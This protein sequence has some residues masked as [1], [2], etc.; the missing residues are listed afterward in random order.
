MV[1]YLM[2]EFLLSGR[3]AHIFADAFLSPRGRTLGCLTP[4]LNCMLRFLLIAEQVLRAGADGIAVIS[5]IT[6]AD[7][8]AEAVRQWQALFTRA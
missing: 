8:V 7:D 5:A 6:K 1:T 2:Y 4:I 3:M